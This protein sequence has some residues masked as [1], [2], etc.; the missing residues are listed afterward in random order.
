MSLRR[1]PEIRRGRRKNRQKRL[2]Q[3]EE[4]VQNKKA[5]WRSERKMA[6]IL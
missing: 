6:D 5:E 4:Q 2:L 1:M 3:K